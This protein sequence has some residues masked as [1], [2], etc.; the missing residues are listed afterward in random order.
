MW[1][2]G[3]TILAVRER[4]GLFEIPIGVARDAGHFLVLSD[5]GIFG[6]GMIEAESGQEILQLAVVWQSSQRCC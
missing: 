2:R 1:I 3:V 5:Q 6:F 4:H